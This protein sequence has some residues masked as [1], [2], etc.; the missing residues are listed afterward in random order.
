MTRKAQSHTT[1]S[2]L[3][4]KLRPALT[5]TIDRIAHTLQPALAREKA[6]AVA[7]ESGIVCHV[8]GEIVVLAPIQL[9]RPLQLADLHG[10][11]YVAAVL[12]TTHALEDCVTRT[13]LNPGAYLLRLR[14][15]GPERFA[16]DFL[17][18]DGEHKLSTTTDAYERKATLRPMSFSKWGINIDIDKLDDIV[19]PFCHTICISILHWRRCFE[20]CK[21]KQP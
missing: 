18:A 2:E 10:R 14:P 1:G 13:V 11:P 21:L 3:L 5:D 7:V 4:L 19:N 17:G 12:A 20:I 9:Q 6:G 8:H 16:F 15:C